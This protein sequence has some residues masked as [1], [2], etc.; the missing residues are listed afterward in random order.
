MAEVGAVPKTERVPQ[1]LPVRRQPVRPEQRHPQRVPNAG[2][3][4]EPEDVVGVARDL[5]ELAD[6]FTALL[7]DG[8]RGYATP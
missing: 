2:D 3:G 4:R 7:L 8:M 5:D 6:R 1:L